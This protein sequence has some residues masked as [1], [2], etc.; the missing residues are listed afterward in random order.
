MQLFTKTTA[1]LKEMML[2]ILPF[3]LLGSFISLTVNAQDCEKFKALMGKMDQALAEKNPA[4]LAEIYHTDAVRIINGVKI[5]GLKALQE[6]AANFYKNVPDAVGTNNDVICSGDYLVVRWTGT[7]T[8]YEA[9]KAVKVTG[10]TIYKTVDG[11]VK[12]EWEEYNDLSM[13]K[14]LGFEL[15]P[16][17]DGKN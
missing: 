14:Q 4:L 17:G 5:E 16:P 13:M 15:K 2:R 3:F 6:D 8:P 7:G 12:E 11:K 1:M 10:I 9:P